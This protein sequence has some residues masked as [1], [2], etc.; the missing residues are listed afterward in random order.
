M[1][2]KTLE[3]INHYLE[4]ANSYKDK[5]LIVL[6]MNVKELTGS[7]SDYKENSIFSEYYSY[8]QYEEILAAI[9]KLE[10][11]VK[12]YFDENHFISDYELGI[13]RN[14]YPQEML[15]I[16]SAQKGTG[17]GRKSLIP[18]FCQLHNI[19]C[20]SSSPYTVNFARNKY[21][22]YCFLKEL[23]FPVCPSWCYSERIGW[24]SEKKPLIGEK[25][26]VKLNSESSSIGLSK[27]NIFKYTSDKEVFINN[28]CKEFEQDVIIEKFISGYEVEVPVLVSSTSSCSLCPSGISVNKETYLGDTIL[29]YSVRG[30]H[31]FDHYPFSQIDSALS[32]ILQQIAEK[33]ALAIGI[34]NMGRIDFRVNNKKEFYITDIATNPHITKSMTFNHIFNNLGLTY[35]KVL[36]TLIGL[37]VTWKKR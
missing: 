31:K 14:H 16:N 36:Q 12:C 22:W 19:L 33:T 37:S 3:F 28:L 20:A 21:H 7:S 27:N 25:V 17:R 26:I 13:L 8:Q 11:P 35:E 2:K 30:E 23:D 24:I 9:K 34:R 32:L 5:L 15:V 10:F 1:H 18:A 6:V 29:D 4:I